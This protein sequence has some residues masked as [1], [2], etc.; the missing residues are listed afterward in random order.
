[1]SL[2]GTQVPELEHDMLDH[3]FYASRAESLDYVRHW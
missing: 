2:L 3:L 1:M